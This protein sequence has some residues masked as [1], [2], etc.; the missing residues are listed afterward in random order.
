MQL[1]VS[2]S[3]PISPSTPPTPACGSGDNV[4]QEN[5][6][7][8]NLVTNE[9]DEEEPNFLSSRGLKYQKPLE[10]RGTIKDLNQ[11]PFPKSVP[12]KNVDMSLRL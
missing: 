11:K 6:G 7:T 12:A 8:T 9:S 1:K 4:G 2:E 3:S 10:R 5:I